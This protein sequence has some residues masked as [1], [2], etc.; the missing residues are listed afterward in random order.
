M[1][2]D[3]AWVIWDNSFDPVKLHHKETI[4]TIGNGYLSTRGAFEEGYPGDGRATF[5]H[6]VFDYAPIVITELA[7]APDWL[8]FDIY[9]N[10]ERFSLGTGSLKDFQQ[11]LDLSNGVLT[12]QVTWESPSGWLA[13]ICFHRF[14]SLADMHVQLIRCEVTP[15]FEGEVEFR[16]SLK[17]DT[18]NQGL[19]HW[20]WVG[21]GEKGE[22]A[23]LL[24]RTRHSNIDIATAMRLRRVTGE[25]EECKYWDVINTPTFN[26]K[27]SAMAG[28]KLCVEK[29]CAIVT[30]RDFMEPV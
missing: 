5:V 25:G 19:A 29:Y 17:G 30:S 27:L 8:P 3:Q 4:F 24:N 13:D 6:G 16:A 14:A 12:R 20:N 21:Q 18:D 9:L 1:D 23:Y 7:N 10:G 28:N 11:A 26:M 22:A 2:N 15:R